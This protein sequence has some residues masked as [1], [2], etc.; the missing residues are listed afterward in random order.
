M[1][2]K[3]KIRIAG[4][5]IV[6]GFQRI[7]KKRNQMRLRRKRDDGSVSLCDD[8]G[9][10]A[11]R[12]RY[13]SRKADC[14]KRKR[15][16]RHQTG[17]RRKRLAHVRLS[18]AALRAVLQKDQRTYK[19]RRNRRNYDYGNERARLSSALSRFLRPRQMEQRRKMRFEFFARQM[20]PR[21]RYYVL[22]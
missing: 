15:I 14:R 16:A 6:R 17:C 10:I 18:R 1:R 21:S 13:S 2:S 4:R 3:R 7:R 8:D 19:L 20:L 11:R 5:Q 22:A 12:I 9:N